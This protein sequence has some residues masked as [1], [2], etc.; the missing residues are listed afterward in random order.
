MTKNSSD[1]CQKQRQSRRTAMSPSLFLRPSVPS[2]PIKDTTLLLPCNLFYSA[3]NTNN[4]LETGLG[5]SVCVCLW[6]PITRLHHSL[7]SSP[8]RTC[9]FQKPKRR[10]DRISGPRRAAGWPLLKQ[11]KEPKHLTGPPRSSLT[12]RWWK[13]WWPR[14]A[15]KCHVKALAKQLIKASRP[16]S[17]RLILSSG[18]RV[19]FQVEFFFFQPNGQSDG[20]QDWAIGRREFSHSRAVNAYCVFFSPMKRIAANMGL[21]L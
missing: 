13:Q 6:R 14:A 10:C 4:G 8:H 1:D 3:P 17:I 16:A 5:V 11:S 15:D 7:I 19:K 12:F 2:T 20:F 21:I 18:R 9:E